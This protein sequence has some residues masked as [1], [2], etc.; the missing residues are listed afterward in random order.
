ME[1]QHLSNESSSGQ[2]GFQREEGD[3]YLLTHT[4]VPRIGLALSVALYELV[5]KDPLPKGPQILILQLV[6]FVTMENLIDL[7][8]FCF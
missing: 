5:L 7:S 3:C 1:R 2:M 8:V 6:G 4:K